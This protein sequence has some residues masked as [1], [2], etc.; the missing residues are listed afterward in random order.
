MFLSGGQSEEDA[1]VNLNAI[2]LAAAA[3]GGGAP[4]ALSCSYGRAL[5]ASVLQ[6]WGEDRGDPGRCRDMAAALARANGQA[7]LGQYRG[8]HPSV[9]SH[10]GSLR[11]SFRGWRTDVP[12]EGPPP[13]PA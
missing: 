9:T 2:N 1:T 4:W 5:Q 10:R 6:L 13:P 11:E 7:A 3:G 8:P 12:P